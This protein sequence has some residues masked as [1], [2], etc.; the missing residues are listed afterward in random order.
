VNSC[1]KSSTKLVKNFPSAVKYCLSNFSIKP[2]IEF[3]TGSHIIPTEESTSHEDNFF[4][5]FEDART[6]RFRQERGLS[7]G[8]WLMMVISPEGAFS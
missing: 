6:F 3:G 2:N 4:G 8:R 5:F 7:P 1:F